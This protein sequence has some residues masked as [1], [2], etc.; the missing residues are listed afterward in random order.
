MNVRNALLAWISE[1]TKGFYD[2]KYNHFKFLE[3]NA[4]LNC[5]RFPS[6]NLLAKR[7]LEESRF[8]KK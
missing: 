6:K 5:R 3:T 2:S 1:K 4:V 8:T 7:V